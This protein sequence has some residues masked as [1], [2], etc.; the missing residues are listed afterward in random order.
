MK[1]PNKGAD[2]TGD[3]DDAFGI[4]DATSSKTPVS[5][6]ESILHAP[7]ESFHFVGLAVL[8]LGGLGADPGFAAIGLGAFAEH[9]QVPWNEA[10]DRDPW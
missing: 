7:G 10:W 4:V 5:F 3:S 2:F 1:V 6:A 8:S 9:P